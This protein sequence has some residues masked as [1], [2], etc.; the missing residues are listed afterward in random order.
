MY[1]VLLTQNLKQKMT[2]DQTVDTEATLS[3]KDAGE[4]LELFTEIEEKGIYHVYDCKNFSKTQLVKLFTT[5]TKKELS[6]F[7]KQLQQFV[8]DTKA[9]RIR[10]DSDLSIRDFSNIIRNHPQ[11]YSLLETWMPQLYKQ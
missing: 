5:T 6:D 10:E 3:Q 7:E 11:D 1:T 4:L 2:E 9:H 8:I